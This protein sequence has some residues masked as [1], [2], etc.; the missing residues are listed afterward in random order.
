MI[1]NE[2][3]VKTCLEYV[4]ESLL[5]KYDIQIIESTLTIDN[6]INVEAILNYQDHRIQLQTSFLIDYVQDHFSFT[7]IKGK[8]EYLFLQLDIINVLKQLCTYDN[9]RINDQELF[10]YYELPIE[11]VLIK[12]HEL[13]IN[14][15]DKPR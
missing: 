14:I 2:K 10:V 4:L 8:I 15:K 3:E 5:K 13:Q 6:F 11:K 7:N 9:I 1:L 12:E